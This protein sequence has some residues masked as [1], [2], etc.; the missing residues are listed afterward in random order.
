[1]RGK[2]RQDS[3]RFLAPT[4]DKKFH[5]HESKPVQTPILNQEK[6][7]AQVV[8]NKKERYFQCLKIMQVSWVGD[9][10]AIWALLLQNNMSIPVPCW[11]IDILAECRHA[12][13]PFS[14]LKARWRLSPSARR[15]NS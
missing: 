4:P 11:G 7:N 10:S 5:L 6:T 8:P 13:F 3:S 12:P 1:M 2:K 15:G 9:F 14:F